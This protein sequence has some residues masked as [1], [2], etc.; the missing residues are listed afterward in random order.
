MLRFLKKA[1]EFQ[2]PITISVAVALPCALI[3]P[4]KALFVAVDGYTGTI[5]PNAPDGNP[6]LG[7]LLQT[8]SFIGGLTVPCTLILLGAS[9]ARLKVPADWHTLPLSSMF[10]MAAIKMIL[11]PLVGVFLV[12]RLHSSTSL[13]PSDDKMR[14]FIGILSSGTPAAV[15]QLVVTQLYNPNGT[16]QTLSMFLLPQYVFMPIFSTGIAAIA[17]YITIKS[18]S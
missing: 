6:P 17:L 2:S 9:F 1:W 18:T 13:F 11:V 14:I 15:N 12:Q 8:A 3:P 10:A 4:V 16:A 7:F 5:I